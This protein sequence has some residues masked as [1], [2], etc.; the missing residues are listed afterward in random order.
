M[1]ENKYDEAVIGSQR[2]ARC[3]TRVLRSWRGAAGGGAAYAAHLAH[4]A[5]AARRVHT[6]ILRPRSANI[7]KIKRCSAQI[8]VFAFLNSIQ[9]K[10]KAL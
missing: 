4:P 2:A 8:L 10:L 7:R 9:G 6:W 3:F 5:G 1:N